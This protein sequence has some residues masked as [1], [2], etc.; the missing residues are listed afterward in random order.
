MDLNDIAMG[1][2]KFSFYPTPDKDWHELYY[3]AIGEEGF[4]TAL[5][6]WDN[7][8]E[9]IRHQ[10]EGYVYASNEMK[11]VTVA[12][13]FDTSPTLIK[14]T[15]VEPV[16]SERAREGCKRAIQIEISPNQYSDAP[17]ITGFCDEKQAIEE[18]YGGLLALTLTHDLDGNILDADE[19]PR[20]VAYNQLKSPI[21]ENFI[22]GQKQDTHTVALRQRSINRVIK[23]IPDYATCFV[24]LS[25]DAPPFSIENDLIETDNLR[26]EKGEKIYIKGYSE[27]L[28][29][30]APVVIAC[31]TGEEHP[32]DWEAYHK[33]GLALAKELRARLAA[34]IDLWYEP[35][36][37]DHSGILKRAV[38]VMQDA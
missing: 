5:S 24:D 22:R 26:D 6:H 30:I 37:E 14:L 11:E 8:F 12:L 19:V 33:R 17:M 38:L 21:I 31:A 35:P 32:F 18:L 34:D 23:I 4:E 13:N 27:W 25:R 15:P 29:A 20:I 10:I 1:I 9:L 7:A 2:K 16:P 28:K 3:I 36:F